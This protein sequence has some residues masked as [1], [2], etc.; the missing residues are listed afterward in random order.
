MITALAQ[1][2]LKQRA[3]LD[4][5]T[6]RPL[7]SAD[8]DR[9]GRTDQ[10]LRHCVELNTSSQG[11]VF[12][13]ASEKERARFLAEFAKCDVRRRS[14]ALASAAPSGVRDSMR[15]SSGSFTEDPSEDNK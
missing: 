1:L 5:A 6:A 11:F 8:L 4:G 9:L 12:S 2:S 7:E 14:S 13:F 15:S 10:P 3:G